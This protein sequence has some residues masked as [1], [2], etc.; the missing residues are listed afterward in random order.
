MKTC[1]YAV[2]LTTFY[3]SPRE[4]VMPHPERLQPSSRRNEFMPKLITI[5]RDGYTLRDFQADALAGL[6][7][8]IVA[9]PLA[10][11]IAIA[12][13]A[14]PER[15]LYTAIAAGFIA[16]L[17]GGSRFQISGPTS[18]FIVVVY[19]T[20]ERH[21]YE[22][23]ALAT[24]MAGLMLVTIGLLRLGAYIKYIPYPVVAGFSAGIAVT[25]LL[26]QIKELLGLD[27]AEMPA[28]FPANVQAIGGAIGTFD[29][30]TIAITM[31]SLAIII[32]LKKIRP[33][34]PGF[35]FAVVIASCITASLGL[36]ISTIQSRFGGV[37]NTLPMPAL[38]SFS[39]ELAMRVLPDAITIALL[40]GIEA[41]LSAVVADGMSGRRHRS[42]CELLAQGLGNIGS[43]IFGGIPATGALARTATNVR[44]GARG[45][46]SG[47]LHAVYLVFFMAVAAPLIGYVPLAALGAVLA[48]VAWNMSD[49]RH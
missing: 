29:P 21:G 39:V 25:I 3:S 15:G 44:A 45:P 2:I 32:G 27:I 43:V 33:N 47:M 10:L 13:G 14:P 23:L 8:A 1:A 40:A 37:P 4:K 49:Y 31:L 34:W 30:A 38:P 24:V 5:F 12:S 35:L 6:T 9:V 26:T 22:G 16:S 36:D 11:A 42:N 41:L 46:M 28:H 48:I 17:F 19:A 18:A 20:I 7:V